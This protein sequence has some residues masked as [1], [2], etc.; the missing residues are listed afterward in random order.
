MLK[1]LVAKH[2]EKMHHEEK[3]KEIMEA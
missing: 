3:M 1:E 2:E